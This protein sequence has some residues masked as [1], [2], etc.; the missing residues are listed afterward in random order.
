VP[1][2][3]DE[4][5]KVVRK[6]R[7]VKGA[8]GLFRTKEK[9]RSEVEISATSFL[10]A[11]VTL[12]ILDRAPYSFQDDI[13]VE[14][15][16]VKPATSEEPKKGLMIWELSLQP[17]QPQTVSFRYAVKTPEDFDL[18]ETPDPEGAR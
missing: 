17:G 12:R 8:A 7:D 11:P 16:E 10:K 14:M 6:A 4:K 2:G 1:L 3:V 5:I 9:T 13:S 18:D 15:E